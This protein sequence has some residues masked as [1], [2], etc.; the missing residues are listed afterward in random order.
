MTLIYHDINKETV[1]SYCFNYIK[2]DNDDKFNKYNLL[3]Y[4]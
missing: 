1:F 4:D 3:S 2:R